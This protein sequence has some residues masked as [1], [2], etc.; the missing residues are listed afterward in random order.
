MEK[1]FE[2]L[3]KVLTEELTIH[4]SIVDTAQSINDALKRK[5]VT[6]VRSLTEMY[7]SYAGQI[8]ACETKR[9]E[10]CDAIIQ[11]RNPALRHLNL[12]NIIQLLPAHEQEGF[13][14]VRL[15]L[16]EKLRE[17]ASINTS[18]QIL[19]SESLRVIA[20]NFE[21]VAQVRNKL[22]GYKKTGIMDNAVTHKSIVNHIA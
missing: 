20:K 9:L 10:V 15:A 4:V 8:E 17:L 21:L 1:L 13:V 14:E 22:A 11:E 19:L 18:N 16:K 6:Q 3:K 2:E 5:N 7:D 12:Q